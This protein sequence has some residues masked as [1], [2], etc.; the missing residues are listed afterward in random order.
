MSYFI[1]SSA[2]LK[3]YVEEP[4]SLRVAQLVE[5]VGRGAVV[6]SRLTTVEVTSALVRRC[7]RG[8]FS[9]DDVTRAIGFLEDD[10]T[11][12]FQVVE[13]DGAA[14]LRAI[15]LI[16][17]HGLRAADAIQLACALLAAGGRPAEAGLTLVSS[18][19]ELNEAAAR[20]GQVV[21]DPK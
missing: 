14:I 19:E 12:R 3:L 7:R 6:I 20:E 8:D 17:R 11:T 5:S 10:V 16:R 13:L 9:A 1:D 2:L 15:S 18:D 21:L 4:G